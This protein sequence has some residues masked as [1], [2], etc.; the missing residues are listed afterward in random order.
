MRGALSNVP[1]VRRPPAAFTKDNTMPG[2]AK[3][4]DDVLVDGLVEDVIDGLRGDLHPEFGVRPYRVFT[5]RRV[6]HGDEIGQGRYTD[7]ENEILPQPRVRNF[8]KDENNAS[9]LSERGEVKIN[10]VSLTYTHDELMG[11][12]LEQS[13]E[14]LFKITEAHGQENPPRYFVRSRPP[15]VDREQDMAWTLYLKHYDQPGCGST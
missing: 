4:N 8:G 9:G 11:S 2:S 14:W 6:W 5:V 13:A 1:A 12:Q 7:V 3:L 15:F 10:E